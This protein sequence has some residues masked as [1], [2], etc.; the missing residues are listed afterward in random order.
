MDIEYWL[1]DLFKD[2]KEAAQK[3]ENFDLHIEAV[4]VKDIAEAIDNIKWLEI[5]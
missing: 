2:I 3:D 5:Y 4:Y 1:T